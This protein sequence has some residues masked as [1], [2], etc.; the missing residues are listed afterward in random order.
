M[1]LGLEEEE[2]L[3]R[4]WSNGEVA[5]ELLG[6][7]KRGIKELEK[8]FKMFLVRDQRILVLFESENP[9]TFVWWKLKILNIFNNKIDICS[10]HWLWVFIFPQRN[11]VI[12]SLIKP[13]QSSNAYENEFF[14]IT[15]DSNWICNLSIPDIN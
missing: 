13:M 6:K 1:V 15:E 5:I 2:R 9:H 11:N 12:G 7:I 10:Q 4:L 8:L 14:Q 3:N